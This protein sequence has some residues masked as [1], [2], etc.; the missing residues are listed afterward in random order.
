MTKWYAT[1]NVFKIREELKTAFNLSS[2][3]P[4][5]ERIMDGLLTKSI[6]KQCVLETL[7]EHL[8]P[9]ET[10]S[11]IAKRFSSDLEDISL[12]YQ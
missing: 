3:D 4:V 7:G 6:V 5:I 11:E 9:E 8:S 2:E 12:K 1:N 10:V